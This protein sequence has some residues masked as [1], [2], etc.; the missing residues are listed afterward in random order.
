MASTAARGRQGRTA[1]PR[2][3]VPDSRKRSARRAGPANA[4]ASLFG[5]GSANRP[6]MGGERTSRRLSPSRQ[7]CPRTTCVIPS[8]CAHAISPRSPQRDIE[9]QWHRKAIDAPGQKDSV[10][11]QRQSHRRAVARGTQIS[12]A[13]PESSG[14]GLPT[15]SPSANPVG[16]WRPVLASTVPVGRA[17]QPSRDDGWCRLRRH[18]HQP[19]LRDAG[20]LSRA[21]IRS[22]PRSK[23]CS[24]SCR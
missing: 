22:R 15:S 5:R 13:H 8:C 6:G 16:V 2:A 4:R 7:L 21:R 11:D 14:R 17:S 20:V 24:A 10:G 23:T 3:G 12:G 18:R 19:A 1:V 9:S